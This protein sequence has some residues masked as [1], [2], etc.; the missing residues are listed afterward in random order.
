MD[1]WPKLPKSS[2]H[3][4]LVVAS[5]M[6]DQKCHSFLVLR[7]TLVVWLML[8]VYLFT[9][10]YS[11]WNKHQD[12]AKWKNLL[13]YIS[14]VSFITIAYVVVKLKIFKAFCIDSVSIKWFILGIFW[15]LTFPNIVWS[16]WNFGHRYSVIR[17][18]LRS[19]NQKYC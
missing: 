17:G 1:F 12:F 11:L 19:E 2:L 9:S 14:L 8:R 18:R 16:C 7:K 6:M 3:F 10:L 4:W 13:R 5:K 15:A